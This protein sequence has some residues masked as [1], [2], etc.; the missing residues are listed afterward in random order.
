[1]K[2]EFGPVAVATIEGLRARG[3]VIFGPG[4]LTP[5]M[6]TPTPDALR[7]L[8]GVHL[9][10]ACGH[11]FVSGFGTTADEALSDALAKLAIQ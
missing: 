7:T 9:Q 5:G 3:C 2:T 6:T 8:P 4:P 11:R 10:I 1:M